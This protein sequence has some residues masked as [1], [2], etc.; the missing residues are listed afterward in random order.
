M[1][2]RPP[3][4]VATVV[5]PG[6]HP[7]ELAVACEVF[8]LE[9][10]ELGVRWYDFVVCGERRRVDLGPFTIEAPAGLEVLDAADTII[11]PA[12]IP[13][14]GTSPALVGALQA[15]YERGARLVSFCSGAFAL[16]EAGVLDGKRATTHW[17]YAAR[18][19]A[20]YPAV[21]VVPDVLYVDDGQVLTSAGTAGGI[22]LSLY[23]VRC[24][25]GSAIANKVAR[26]MVMPPHRDGGQAQF[27]D[28]PVP[29]S[30]DANAL[31]PTLDWIVD[32]LAEPITVEV[33]AAHA[34]MSCRT[35]MRRFRAATGTTPLRWL[36]QQRVA[37]ARDLLETTDLPV[38]RI[39]SSCG[40]GTAANLRV[41]FL[42]TVG[43]SP[44]AY[45]RTFA[46][47]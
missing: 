40:F 39:A 17:M 44:S 7:F 45:R 24:D 47:A 18:L 38:D 31:G 42:R 32:N 1:P 3:H 14:L 19:A 15:A 4:L 2:E 35:F 13:D 11:I 46:A 21:D 36:L 26:R 34:L 25:Y 43:T 37:H 5:Q 20:E 6:N 12:Q 10:P 41:H 29:D 28:Q 33:M 30:D 23:M 9:R 22:D 8:G 27:V 16:A